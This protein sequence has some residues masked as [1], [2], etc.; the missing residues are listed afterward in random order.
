MQIRNKKN[1]IRAN[2]NAPANPTR[3]SERK[4]YPKGNA[5]WYP[6]DKRLDGPHN[7]FGRRGEEKILPLL[8]LEV[9][10]LSRLAR[11]QSLYKMRYEGM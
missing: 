1:H 2:C 3:A 7:R 4:L 11:S 5:P 10:P 9:S 6:L 8:G